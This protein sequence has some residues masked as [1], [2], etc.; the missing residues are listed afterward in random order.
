MLH[1]VPLKMTKQKD[2]CV[3]GVCISLILGGTKVKG[4]LIIHIKVLSL[5]LYIFVHIL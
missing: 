1:T 5:I 4:I 3:V 2:V